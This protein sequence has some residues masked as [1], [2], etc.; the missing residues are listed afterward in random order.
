MLLLSPDSWDFVE[1]G[2]IAVTPEN[3]KKDSKAL[4]FIQQAIDNSIFSYIVIAKKANEV[5]DT[6]QREYQGSLKVLIIQIQTLHH[7]FENIFMQA[8]ENIHIYFSKVIEI[9]TQMRSY[10]EDIKDQKAIEKNP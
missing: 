8:N 9:I 5:W 1:K 7:K 4:I 6:L 10:S 3:V 2:Y